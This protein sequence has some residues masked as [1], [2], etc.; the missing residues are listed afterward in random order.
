G[1]NKSI[2]LENAVFENNEV[3]N[4]GT[5]SDPSVYGGA[6]YLGGG[7]AITANLKNV[8]FINNS[9]YFTQ[10]TSTSS[11]GG[12]IAF[13]STTVDANF[14]NLTFVNNTAHRGGAVYLRTATTTA[15]IA[16]S[17]FYNNEAKGDMGG[18][19]YVV[20]GMASLVN[21]TLYAN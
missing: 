7:D 2:T 17:L 19:F 1:I 20:N 9:A 15:T 4:G 18:A 14:S 16:N 21:S 11:Y 10:S 8:A 13:G 6:I 5:A 3:Y 12:A